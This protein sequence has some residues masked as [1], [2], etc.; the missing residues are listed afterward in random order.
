MPVIWTFGRQEEEEEDYMLKASTSYT[1]RIFFKM[2]RNGGLVS[3]FRGQR[4]L[5][6][7]PCG[8]IL[9]PEPM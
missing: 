7:K 2:K 9:V 4:H 3:W 5:S 6:C 1:V 8:M